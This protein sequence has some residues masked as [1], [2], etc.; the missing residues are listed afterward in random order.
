MEQKDKAWVVNANEAIQRTCDAI[1]REYKHVVDAFNQQI[2]NRCSK[3]KHEV[4]YKTDNENTCR[5]LHYFYLCLGYKVEIEEESSYKEGVE[6]TIY[7]LK[8]IW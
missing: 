5:D 7:K 4:I 3:R 8:L 6:Y 2:V 1:Y